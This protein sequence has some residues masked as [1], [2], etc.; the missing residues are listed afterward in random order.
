MEKNRIF[1][2]TQVV[3]IPALQALLDSFG[4][5]TLTGS[6]VLDL[7]GNIVTR[8]GWQD[9]CTKFHRVC[10]Q[11]AVRCRESDT[12]LS[13]SLREGSRYNIYKCKNGMVDVAVPIMI[14]KTHIGNLFTGQFFFSPPDLEFFSKQADEFAFDK[15][16]YL[17]ALAQV[18]I[19]SEE[20]AEKTINFLCLVAASLGKMGMARLEL[21][22]LNDTLKEQVSERMQ[23]EDELQRH[24]EHLQELVEERTRD[25]L[26]SRK[27]AL[28]LMQDANM[29]RQRAEA[30]LSKLQAANEESI[31]QNKELERARDEAR[32]ALQSKS[33]FVATMSHEIRTPLS[34][35]LGMIEVLSRTELS[36]QQSSYIQTAISAGNSLKALLNDIVTFSKIEAGKVSLEM[37]DFDLVEVVEKAGELFAF[38]AAE[39]GLSLH[40]FVDPK[41]PPC[42][43]NGDPARLGEILNNLISNAIKFSERGRIVVGAT[44]EAEAASSV[45]VHFSVSDTGIGMTEE[46]LITGLFEAFTQAD[47]SI[48]RKYGGAGLGLFISNRLVDLMGGKIS[49][50]S[51]PRKGARFEF[52]LSFQ[53]SVKSAPGAFTASM[54]SGIRILLVDA[55]P[56]ARE[57][58]QEYL[59]SWG[60]RTGYAASAAEGLRML[61]EAHAK[62]DRYAIAIT[63]NVVPENNGIELAQEIAGD[64]VLKSTKIVILNPGMTSVPP[65][66]AMT[67]NLAVYLCKP[68]KRSPLLDTLTAIIEGAQ[69]TARG[70]AEKSDET[71]TLADTQEQVPVRPE[72]ILVVEDHQILQDVAVLLLRDFGFEADV[73]E[74][75][76]SALKALASV[77]YDLVFMDIGMPEMDGFE[78]TRI[79]RNNDIHASGHV[80][81]IAMT[82]EAMEG[83][84][85]LCIASGMDDYISKPVDIDQLRS[86]IE[87]W[88][89]VKPIDIEGLETRY[90][91][92]NIERILE[93]FVN[94]TPKLIDELG[95]S[96]QDRDSAA[97][98]RSAHGLKGICATVIANNMQQICLA[99]ETAGREKN[100]TVLPSLIQ[101][102]DGAFK[103]TQEFAKDRAW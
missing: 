65:E 23:V 79:I 56:N 9:I 32:I 24:R 22:E 60:V 86:I 13:S 74:S 8:T 51:A 58:L 71:W 35:M 44:L 1:S 70:P 7:E 12:V 73:A 34:G 38:S 36:R 87:K 94:D 14:D 31:R 80:P 66:Q 88:L 4:S 33:E 52:T 18:P 91:R 16:S 28:S 59:V 98:L 49:V 48:T 85:E 100:W 96:V 53:K 83:T 101:R 17:Q 103:E 41:I 3:D 50:S 39:K 64:P 84:R 29:Q 55:D 57:I 30:A 69:E 93:L 40:T 63:D 5:A 89:P 21:E 6:A 47:S 11:T 27:A 25:L 2:I 92:K 42:L 43:L 19:W 15:T 99:I 77:R 97:V 72:R 10:P 37:I 67:G 61:R 75:G 45:S 90:G 62:D 20:Q 26:Q 46:Q 76:Q 54:L 95:R 68:I 82:A 78:V 102:L 81:V